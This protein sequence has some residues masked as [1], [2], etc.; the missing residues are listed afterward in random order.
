M[1]NLCKT[2]RHLKYFDKDEPVCCLLDNN[3]NKLDCIH[4]DYSP[5]LT[6]E[7]N[8]EQLGKIMVLEGNYNL[9]EDDIFTF[10]VE[11]THNDLDKDNT[12]FS[13]S[14]LETI[15]N[16]CIGHLTVSPSDTEIRIY[17]AKVESLNKK[18]FDLRPYKS[19]VA[20][21]YILR[22]DH[23]KCTIDWINKN[24]NRLDTSIS[25]SIS[26]K[27]LQDSGAV[28]ISNVDEFMGFIFVYFTYFNEFE[29][30][31]DYEDEDDIKPKK[32]IKKKDLKERIEKLENRVEELEKIIEELNYRSTHF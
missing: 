2:C 11:L 7:K 17:E 8:Q 22:N 20:S 31:Y 16:Q 26:S 19:L 3:V 24:P 23:N 5:S 27:T 30:Q 21:C 29:I 25:C 4:Y 9:T 12:Y 13:D 28:E 14:A 10:N 6:K 32:K 18:T 1:V 15:A